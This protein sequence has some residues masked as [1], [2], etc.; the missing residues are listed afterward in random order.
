MEKS[1]HR[2][3][4]QVCGR[5]QAIVDGSM[6]KH[7]YTVAGF[8]YF[9]GVCSGAARKPLEQD[10]SMTD[11][12]VVSLNEYAVEQDKLCSQY[13]AGTRQ[14]EFVTRRVMQEGKRVDVRVHVTEANEYEIQQANRQAAYGH[15]SNAR[16]AVAH[17]DMLVKLAAQVHGQALIPVAKE[18]KAPV[19][20][21]VVDVAAGT[22][23]GAYKTKA[24]RQ[25]DLDALNRKFDV[26]HRSIQ[27]AYLDSNLRDNDEAMEIYY[28]PAGL[29]AWRAKHSVSVRK[30]FPQLEQVVIAIEQLVKAREAVKAA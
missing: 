2:G 1:T 9:H 8:G 29:H 11:R 30:F 3:H 4:C 12:I 17:A 14:V 22:V 5:I 23:T 15:E 10:R 24:A 21:P 16:Q 25:A 13:K 19:V 18:A 20:A 27:Q 28:G 6:A 7:G 26:L